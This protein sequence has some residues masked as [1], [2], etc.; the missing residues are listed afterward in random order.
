MREIR[1][2]ATARPSGSVD[3]EIA[4]QLG[5]VP[6]RL[7]VV[8]GVLDLPVGVI[9]NANEARPMP[10]APRWAASD[11]AAYGEWLIATRPDIT[12]GEF[13]D[14]TELAYLYALEDGIDSS[15]R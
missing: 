4:A 12:F 5:H 11:A 14:E 3:A 8:E 2:V 7:D 13:V 1:P 9:T 6:G 15:E 10:D